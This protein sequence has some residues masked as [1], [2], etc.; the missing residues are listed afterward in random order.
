MGMA[1]QILGEALTGWKSPDFLS[2]RESAKE[3]HIE[4]AL[5]D[6]DSQ[7]TVRVGR[8]DLLLKMEDGWVLVDYKTSRP[9]KDAGVWLHSQMELHRP[10]LN[11]YAQMVARTLKLPEEKIEWAILFTALPRLVWREEKVP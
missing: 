10:Q 6:F 8:F 4:V 3:I 11:A 7:W 2:L 1:H 9:E 5:E